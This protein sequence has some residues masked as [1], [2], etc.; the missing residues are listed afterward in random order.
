MPAFT[1]VSD[2]VIWTRHV[3]G[4]DG[5]LSRLMA[6]RA[7]ETVDI[8][9][10][11]LKGTWCKMDDGKDGRSTPGLKP[12]GKT[13]VLWSQLYKSRRGEVVTLELAQ[14][15]DV[16]EKQNEEG[17][18]MRTS[19]DRAAAHEALSMAYKNLWSPVPFTFD[20]S[21]AHER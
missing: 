11:G 7:G 8:R 4:D 5:A 17:L 3:H 13:K 14:D 12:L 6:L 10:D 21:A 19:S 20:R 16:Y 9:I 15:K 1:T 2:Y 18:I